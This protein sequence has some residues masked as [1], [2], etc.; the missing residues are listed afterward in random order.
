MKTCRYCPKYKAVY[1][2]RNGCE[3]CW[4]FFFQRHA[5]VFAPIAGAARLDAN[6]FQVVEKVY[7]HELRKQ[8]KK[9]WRLTGESASRTSDNKRSES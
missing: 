6:V 8:F 7:G 9:L 4:H 3:T 2:P 5:Q 1:P